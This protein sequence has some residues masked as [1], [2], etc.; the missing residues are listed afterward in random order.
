MSNQPTNKPDQYPIINQLTKPIT[1][2]HHSAQFDK[3]ATRVQSMLGFRSRSHHGEEPGFFWRVDTR[4]L[5]RSL[6]L[7]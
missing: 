1:S 6:G 4:P 7:D 2:I 5:E 3:V